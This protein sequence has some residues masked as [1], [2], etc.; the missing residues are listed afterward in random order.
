[1]VKIT[2]LLSLQN[3]EI[4]KP[5][6]YL[7]VNKKNDKNNISFS[8]SFQMVFRYKNKWQP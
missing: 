6:K 2:K 7:I 4:T 5:I 3:C 8:F 1:M